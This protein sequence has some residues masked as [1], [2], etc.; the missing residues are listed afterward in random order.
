[1]LPSN[2]TQQKEKENESITQNSWFR[3]M[4]HKIPERGTI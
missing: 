3:D 2:L 4:Y 1:M